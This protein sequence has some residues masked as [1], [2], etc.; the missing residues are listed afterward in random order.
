MQQLIVI[1]C[2]FCF[3][4]P[5]SHFLHYSVLS[6][7]ELIFSLLAYLKLLFKIATDPF[8]SLTT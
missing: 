1:N 5:V 6:Q 2:V 4:N 3:C 7:N 8:R